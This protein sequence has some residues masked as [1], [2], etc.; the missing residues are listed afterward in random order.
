MIIDNKVAIITGG[1]SGL[2]EATA[3][4]L[5]NKGAKVAILDMNEDK[6]NALVAELGSNAIFFKTNIANTEDVKAAVDGTKEKFGS[7]DIVVPCAGRGSMAKTASKKGAHDLEAFRT[8]INVNLIGTFDVIRQSAVYMMQNEPNEDGERGVIVNCASVAAFEGQV[9]QVAYAASKAG[10]V[11]MTLV[12]ARD[13]ADVG[14]RCCTIAPGTFDTP[15]IAPLPDPIKAAIA[16]TI[17]FP[18]RFGKPDEFAMLVEQIINN[19]MLNGEVIRLDGAIRMQ[20][21]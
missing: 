19:P 4:R 13:L 15:I 16:K 2:G 8:V 14:V 3:R 7:V 5:L 17:P 1:A 20:P 10:M 21:K 12:I 11:G 18:S 6:G 9:G